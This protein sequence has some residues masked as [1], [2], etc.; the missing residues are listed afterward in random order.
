MTTDTERADT[1]IGTGSFRRRL[2]EGLPLLGTFLKTPSPILVEVLSY[3]DLDVLCLDAEHA[4]FGRAELDACVAAARGLGLSSIV[5]VAAAHREQIGQALDAGAD[6]V[7][8][9]HVSSA[10]QTEDVVRW[11]HFGADGRGYAGSHRAAGYTTVPLADHLRDAAARTAVIV[12]IEDAEAVG[13]ADAIAAVPGVDAIFVGPVDLAVSIGASG[14]E[15]PTVI[16][17]IEQVVD[18]ARSAD[19]RVGCFASS[20]TSI[21]RLRTMGIDFVL[22][23][24]DQTF[25]LGGA[26]Q[27]RADFPAAVQPKLGPA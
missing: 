1:G 4:P 24:S 18:A 16:A 20:P 10:A 21:Q 13:E 9:P 8:V 15:D 11:A 22:S 19:C 3:A 12:Q 23:G 25:V 17:A 26:R 5:R 27:L 6:G 14:P 2:H 7:L